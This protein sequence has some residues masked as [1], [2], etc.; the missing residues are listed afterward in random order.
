VVVQF[1]YSKQLTHLVWA[2]LFPTT[3][4]HAV[5]VWP[6]CSFVSPHIITIFSLFHIINLDKL[7]AACVS[8]YSSMGFGFCRLLYECV[9]A[10]LSG[11]VNWKGYVASVINGQL[12]ME[13]WWSD[14]A[15]ASE[16]LEE[17]PAPLPF[18][19][20]KPHID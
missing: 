14:A 19:Q 16:V 15:M 11:A 17:K 10:L 7:P 12:C 18:V 5:A 3:Q 9:C 20:H 8:N 2:F 13:H 1:L 4:T 6:S